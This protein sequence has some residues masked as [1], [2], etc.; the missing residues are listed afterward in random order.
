MR[1]PRRVLIFDSEKKELAAGM[2]SL[3]GSGKGTLSK[4]GL[5]YWRMREEN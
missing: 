1:G 4:V 2:A 5:E 3:Y